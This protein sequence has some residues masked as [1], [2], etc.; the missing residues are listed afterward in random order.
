MSVFVD[1]PVLQKEIRSRLRARRQSRGNRIAS[2]VVTGVVLFLMYFFGLQALW[3]NNSRS[4][5]ND[6]YIGLTLGIELTL[7]LFLIPSLTAPIITQEREQQTWNAL[8]LS[9]LSNWQIVVGKFVSAILPALVI[10]LLFFPLAIIAAITGNIGWERFIWS[11]L[12]LLSCILFYSSIGLFW[13]WTSRRTAAA[14]SATF[15]TVMFFVLITV[16]IWGLYTTATQ[17][18]STGAHEFFLMWLNPYAALGEI[19]AGGQNGPDHRE[20]GI[21]CTIL[22]FLASFA[23]ITMVASRLPFGAKDLEQ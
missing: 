17:S 3:Q 10:L 8:L 2:Y 19:L 12:F 6:L 23:L 18:Y 9:R 14:T 5:G 16:L 1:N 21:L 7:I 15:A 13:S 20:I 4:S 22:Y 11:N